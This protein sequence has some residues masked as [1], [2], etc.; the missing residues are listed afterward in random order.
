MKKTQCVKNTEISYGCVA[1]T[2]HWLIALG[3]ISLLT[4]GLYM[5]G[6]EK[7]EFR[8]QVY[9]V[10]KATGILILVLVVVRIIWRNM[11]VQPKLPADIPAYQ[12]FAAHFLHYNLYVLML[13]IPLSGW[14]MSSAG[15]HPVSF[16]GLFTVPPLVGEDK[17]LGGLAREAH[18]I[19]AYIIIA[20]ISLHILAA[21]YH[22]FIVKDEVLKRML[23]ECKKS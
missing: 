6:L 10:H 4:V 22:H 12:K 13:L 7:G 5:T 18:W 3:I 15:G 9:G 16:Y 17:E 11:N 23:P 8:G 20:L 21:L 19:L 1:K 2:L 14:T